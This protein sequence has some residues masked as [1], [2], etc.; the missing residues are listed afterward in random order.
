MQQQEEP[1]ALRM[2]WWTMGSATG[3]EPRM[4][5][6]LI[7]LEVLLA[8]AVAVIVTAYQVS[9]SSPGFL[10]LL[11]VASAALVGSIAWFSLR[12]YRAS[13]DSRGKVVASVSVVA[14]LALVGLLG[15][16]LIFYYNLH[17]LVAR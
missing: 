17:Q 5:A 7:G 3:S 2:G 11:G 10:I 16:Y 6:I 12:L 8:I 1:D 9:V 4:V 13:E 14:A 15:A